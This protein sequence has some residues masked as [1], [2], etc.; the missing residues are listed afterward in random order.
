ME[1]A[2]A[3]LGVEAAS[4]AVAAGSEVSLEQAVDEALAWLDA[5]ERSVPAET[6]SSLQPVPAPASP[7][8]ASSAPAP[9]SPGRTPS[10]PAHPSPAGT[11]SAPMLPAGTDGVPLSPRQLEV[12]ALIARGLTNRQIADELVITEGT[13]ANHVKAILAS[14][15][16]ESRVQVAVWAIERG[17]R[18]KPTP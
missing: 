9:P 13:A 7:S 15:G 6:P 14:L 17:L 11:P 10:V 2:R 12:A 18:E 4:A 16:L 1:R 3:T 8:G 5:S